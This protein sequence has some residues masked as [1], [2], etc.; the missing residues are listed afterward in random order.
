MTRERA[1]TLMEMLLVMVI[2]GLL[3]ALVLPRLVGI[4]GQSKEKAARAQISALK[5][6]LKSFDMHAGRLPTT[7][8][9]LDALVRRP[10]GLDE[11]QWDG[12]YLDEPEIPTDPW[13]NAYVYRNEGESD[14]VLF[15]PGPDGKAG[16]EDDVGRTAGR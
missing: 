4:A 11:D 12:P 3:A 8:E 1:F 15:S 13:G 14:Y 2:I 5:Q 6:G 9:G 16:T 10:A 7:A